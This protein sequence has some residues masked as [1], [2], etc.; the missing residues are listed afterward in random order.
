MNKYNY[1][2]NN[3][4]DDDKMLSAFPS[5][6]STAAAAGFSNAAEVRRSER[7]DGGVGGVGAGEGREA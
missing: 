3:N 5:T 6:L 1:N 7:R 2:Y 4:D